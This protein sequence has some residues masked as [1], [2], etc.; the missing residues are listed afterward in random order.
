M[1]MTMTVT[2]IVG[3]KGPI[4]AMPRT[5]E[6]RTKCNWVFNSLMGHFAEFP[7]PKAVPLPPAA[8]GLVPRNGVFAPLTG[9][10][11]LDLGGGD[12]DGDIVVVTKDMW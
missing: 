4:V 9:P 10:G 7:A 8:K 12:L 6:Y 5:M 3:W 11:I 2:I 1:A